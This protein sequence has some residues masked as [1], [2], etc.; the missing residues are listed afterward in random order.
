MQE[1][2]QWREDDPKKPSK[3]SLQAAPEESAKS[4]TELE[5][6]N[7]TSTKESVVLT[8]NKA[9]ENKTCPS[10]KGDLNSHPCKQCNMAKLFEAYYGDVDQYNN[11]TANSFEHK[12]IL[13]LERYDQADIFSEDRNRAFYIMLIE[14]DS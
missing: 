14:H 12:F 11:G 2:L 1:E 13:F 5:S 8:K 3:N 7:K 6:K 10:G 9:F 4:G